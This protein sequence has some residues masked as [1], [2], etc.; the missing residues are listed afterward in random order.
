M[1]DKP[2]LFSASM[3]Q[4]L[5]QGRKSQ[6]RR[7]LTDQTLW[8]DDG[9]VWTGFMGWQPVE[10][11]LGNRGAVGK[12][13]LPRYAPGDRLWVKETYAYVGT[14]DPGWLLYRA[15]YDECCRAHGFD[16]P[17]PDASEVA[18]KPSIFMPRRLSRLT[19]LVTDVRV[20]RLQDISE[21]DARAEGIDFD[22]GEGGTFHVAGLAGCGSDS[23][24]DAYRKLWE[25]INGPGSWAANPWV[26]V[27]QFERPVARLDP[28]RSTRHLLTPEIL[29]AEDA[30]G[31]VFAAGALVPETGD[32][33]AECCYCHDPAPG[34]LVAEAAQGRRWV[35]GTLEYHCYTAKVW[36]R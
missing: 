7:A 19:L 6:T 32:I 24:V 30:A 3:I 8:R 22:P 23:A 28:E 2:I 14:T 5:L 36:G 33:A 21:A 27:V 1:A 15:T 31:G 26:W 17:V 35:G 9:T 20:Q 11:A 10:W 25:A 4:A 18:W 12:G 13:V 16:Q 29:E 34:W